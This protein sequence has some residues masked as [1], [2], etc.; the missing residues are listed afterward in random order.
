MRQALAQAGVSAP[1]DV[2]FLSATPGA[3]EAVLAGIADVLGRAVPVM[4]GSAADQGKLDGAW[5]VG[6]A[7]PTVPTTLSAD[8]VAVTLLWPTVPTQLVFSSA[9]APTAA[10]GVVTRAEGREA[11]EINGRPAAEVYIQWAAKELAE[12]LG[13]VDLTPGELQNENLL[14]LSTLRPLASV[15]TDEDEAFYTLLHPSG[16]TARGGLTFFGGCWGEV[17]CPDSVHSHVPHRHQRSPR[18]AKS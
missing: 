4:G 18:R 15:T 9:Y 3:E 2:V 5:W 8:A 13:D 12:Q 16:V 14:A 1:P 17:S 7:S 10:R 6:A 11:V